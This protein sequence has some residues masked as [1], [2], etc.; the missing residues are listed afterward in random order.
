MLDL[1]KSVLQSEEV[2]RQKSEYSQYFAQEQGLGVSGDKS[3][4][5]EMVAKFYNLVTDFYEY[6]WGECFHFAAAK[7]G[8]SHSSGIRRHD[9]RI[10]DA[11]EMNA[12]K[13]CLDVGCGVGGP[14]RNIARYT[15]GRV[16]GV[17]INPYQVER[18]TYHTQNSDVKDL[19]QS[20]QGNFMELDKKFPRNH[21]DCAYAIE[22]TCHAPDLTAC[23]TQVFNVLKPG[24]KFATYEWL[25]TDKYDRTIQSH[26]AAID[27]I[28]IANG[29]PDMRTVA[30]ALKAAQ[31][32]GFTVL[33]H[34][35]I[36]HHP[37]C[38]VKWYATLKSGRLLHWARD[39][40][41]TA[42][43]AI[44]LV[45]RGTAEIHRMLTK[46]AAALV[47]GGEQDVFT[48]MYLIVMQKP[49]KE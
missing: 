36:A 39:C 46:T 43:E 40:A 5:P 28:N 1:G 41:L 42:A 15:K 44:H 13:H 23:Y 10:A 12:S 31:D 6:G 33:H 38:E 25:A 27:G 32:A 17:T 37:S 21:F 26:H 47:S 4:T 35:D 18:G 34:E 22:A 30:Q 20:V 16:T 45:P 49:R 48:P 8:E 19:C 14:M 3:K 24:A 2:H 11:I 9:E 7:K 29:L